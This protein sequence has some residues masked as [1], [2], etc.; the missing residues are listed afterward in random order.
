[1]SLPARILIGLVLGLGLGIAHSLWGAGVLASAPSVVEPLGTLWVNAIRM[2]VIPLIVALLITSI[3]GDQKSGL[4]AKLGGKTIGLFIIMVAAACVFTVI[5]APP[6]MS[7]L[8]ID[9]EAVTAI[10]AATGSSAAAVVE[11]PPFRDWLVSLIPQNPFKAI[12]ETDMLPVLIFTA[13][14]SVA[15]LRIE[16]TERATILRFSRL[17]RTRCLC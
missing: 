10:R 8:V 17:S 7:F 11:L 15:L 3:A 13:L 4:V 1:M 5:L 2:T 14:F 6:L 16:G 9:T 12:V